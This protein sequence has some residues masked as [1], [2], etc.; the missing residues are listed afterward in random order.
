MYTA[1]AL[2]KDNSSARKGRYAQSN[3][4]RYYAGAFFAKE[5]FED[6]ETQKDSVS[7]E[8]LLRY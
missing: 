6:T 3:P 2:F 7:D 1:E 5:A 4:I 8:M